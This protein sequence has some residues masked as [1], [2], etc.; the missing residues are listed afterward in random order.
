MILSSGKILLHYWPSS[1]ESVKKFTKECEPLDLL[2]IEF[3]RDFC[4]LYEIK[5]KF[6]SLSMIPDEL[7]CSIVESTYEAT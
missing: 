4:D 7:V 2:T 1:I 5:R 6:L 3:V